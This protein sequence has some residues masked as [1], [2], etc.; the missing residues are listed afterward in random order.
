MLL[1]HLVPG[2]FA[3]VRS[4]ATWY[5]QWSQ[6]QRL[7]LWVAALGSTVA[8]DLDVIYNFVFRGVFGHTILWTHSIFPYLGLAFVW[9][10]LR[11]N[12]QWT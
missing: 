12:G 8:P 3:A 10:L 2:Y 11:R 5:P 7:A 4:Q 1:A 6:N 9:W